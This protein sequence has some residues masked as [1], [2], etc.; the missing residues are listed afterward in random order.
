MP[1]Y[2]STGQVFQNLPSLPG[3]FLVQLSTKHKLQECSLSTTKCG[4]MNDYKF[5]SSGCCSYNGICENV[6]YCPDNGTMSY[7][8]KGFRECVYDLLDANEGSPAYLAEVKNVGS[9][10]KDAEVAMETC[11]ASKSQCGKDS[12][13]KFCTVGC[14]S[15]SG[16]CG[17]SQVYCVG[18]Y[19]QQYD[20]DQLSKCLEDIGN[21]APAGNNDGA[22]KK[23]FEKANPPV[24]KVQDPT[25]LPKEENP[26][27]IP[28]E[29]DSTPHAQ[30]ETPLPLPKEEVSTDAE[31]TVIVTDIDANEQASEPRTM[32]RKIHDLVYSLM[33]LSIFAFVATYY[34]F[35][36]IIYFCCLRKKM[37]NAKFNKSRCFLACLTILSP[38]IMV[39]L[40][41]KAVYKKR[42]RDIVADRLNDKGPRNSVD[43]REYFFPKTN[44]KFSFSPKLK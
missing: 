13:D 14:C 33:F 22:P 4:P 37:V 20:S 5:C 36:A 17:T 44:L 16:Y 25:P 31:D 28:K 30:E 9:F 7:T 42:Y 21:S 34:I 15:N 8:L 39:I 10:E 40:M 41:V 1:R 43:I 11:P 35:P 3:G 26:S 12:G 27:T 38:W 19:N 24:H 29:K 6:P 18:N 23:E 32:N 2:L